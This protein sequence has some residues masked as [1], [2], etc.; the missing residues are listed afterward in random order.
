MRGVSFLRRGHASMVLTKGGQ[1]NPNATPGR[2]EGSGTV[3]WPTGVVAKSIHFSSAAGGGHNGRHLPSAESA[4][5]MAAANNSCMVLGNEGG[6]PWKAGA[7]QPLRNSVRGQADPRAVL[8]TACCID[9]ASMA[10]HST[11]GPCRP[12]K[13]R[14]ARLTHA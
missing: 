5:Q 4:E 14:F 1:R 9:T 8:V 11:P 7:H 3:C 2:N 10:H 13:R 6:G 12:T